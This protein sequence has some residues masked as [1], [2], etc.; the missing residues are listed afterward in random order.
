MTTY[1][2][3]AQLDGLPFGTIITPADG[4]S[5]VNTAFHTHVSGHYLVC[6]SAATYLAEALLTM[7]PVWVQVKPREDWPTIPPR[8]PSCPRC[9]GTGY[10][11]NTEWHTVRCT[12]CG[13]IPAR[14]SA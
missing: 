8:I 5:R 6:G 13:I 14:R 11:T 3:A 1:T 10:V 4:S 12:L 7:A 2:T 9:A